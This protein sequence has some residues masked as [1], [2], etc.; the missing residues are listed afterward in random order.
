MRAAAAAVLVA[1]AACSEP[2]AFQLRLTWRDGDTYACPVQA[3]DR[4][5]DAVP[6]SCAARVWLRVLSADGAT[7]YH[8]S[9]TDIPEG[10][11]LCKLRDVPLPAIELPNRMVRI[12]MLV[13]SV[14]EL[15][16]AGYDGSTA[17]LR[18]PANASF[19]LRGAPR[20]AVPT[21]AVGGEIF[22]PVGQR[23]VAELP[24]FCP[25]YDQLDTVACR[26]RSVTL[27][28]TAYFASGPPRRVM[29]MFADDLDV[30]WGTPTINEEGDWVLDFDDLIA[31]ESAPDAH[32]TQTVP[33]PLEDI[34]CV[35]VL[36]Q[37]PPTTATA[38]CAPPPSLPVDPVPVIGFR[39][40]PSRE[41]A[42]IALYRELTGTAVPGFPETGMVLGFVVDPGNNAIEGAVV[43]PSGPGTVVYPILPS[44]GSFPSYR[45]D[46]TG[47]G[48][49]F[50]SVDAPHG[51]VW[52]ADAPGR[53]TAVPGHAGR[54]RFHLSTTVVRMQPAAAAP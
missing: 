2:D 38:T 54:I 5:C 37:D 13:W 41:D 43:T 31:L 34:G 10:D 19:D 6:V 30:R 53:V 52:T 11:D 25:D 28:A 32:W 45:T 15:E 22:F 39:L 18:C 3:G 42:V 17:A 27:D 33:G 29:E 1:L 23:E 48:G 50:L 20:L 36:T 4:T 7:V 24:L 47:P 21:P 16:R 40:D 35:R 46:A 14:D 8:T 51:T 12:Q 44:D 49:Y 9:C 26:N